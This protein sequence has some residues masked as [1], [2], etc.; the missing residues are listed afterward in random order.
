MIA[1]W[2]SCPVLNGSTDGADPNLQMGRAQEAC[3]L[4]LFIMRPL[5]PS[6]ETILAALGAQM[7]GV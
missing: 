7:T 6:D 3:I 2:A 4:Q 5:G 1:L